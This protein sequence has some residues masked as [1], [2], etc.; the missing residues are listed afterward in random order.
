MGLTTVVKTIIVRSVPIERILCAV[1]CLEC[2]TRVN[3]QDTHIL[4]L[5]V[6]LS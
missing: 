4:E 1:R 5:C 3:L 2:F 6:L